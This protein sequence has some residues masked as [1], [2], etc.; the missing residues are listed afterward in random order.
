MFSMHEAL[1]GSK[2]CNMPAAAHTLPTYYFLAIMVQLWGCKVPTSLC[3]WPFPLVPK[4]VCCHKF[5]NKLEQYNLIYTKSTIS[6]FITRHLVMVESQAHCVYANAPWKHQV[7][8]WLSIVSHIKMGENEVPDKQ[9]HFQVLWDVF[10]VDVEKGLKNLPNTQA[11][12]KS[13]QKA[14]AWALGFGFALSWARP[15]PILSCHL[16]LAWL[17]LLELS[18]ARPLAWSQAWHNTRFDTLE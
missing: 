2:P 3:P 4:M 15:K 7:I 16:G 10:Y 13:R 8:N 9:N 14:A 17:S 6:V 12:L 18:S 1:E 5:A 11:V